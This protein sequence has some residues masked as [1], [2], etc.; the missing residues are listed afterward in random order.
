MPNERRLAPTL[1]P[2]G[3]TMTGV[4]PSGLQRGPGEVLGMPKLI[5]IRETT[6]AN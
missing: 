4:A 6:D 1:K 5:G 3:V 2:K